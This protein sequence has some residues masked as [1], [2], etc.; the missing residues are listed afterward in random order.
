MG[1]DHTAEVVASSAR[2]IDA[3]DAVLRADAILNQ[4][5]NWIARDLVLDLRQ[6]A[7]IPLR[8]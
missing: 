8:L 2:D 7:P 1:G 4:A 6:A 5:S 3:A